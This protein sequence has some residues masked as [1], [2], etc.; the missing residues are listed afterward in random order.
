MGA[1]PLYLRPAQAAGRG[2]PGAEQGRRIFATASRLWHTN[3]KRFDL[4]ATRPWPGSRAVI[5]RPRDGVSR[6]LAGSRI[7]MAVNAVTAKIEMAK[8]AASQALRTN[9]ARGR[10]L[11]NAHSELLKVRAAGALHSE[12]D[13]A[14]SATNQ[15]EPRHLIAGNQASKKTLNKINGALKLRGRELCCA[16]ERRRRR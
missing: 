2:T 12:A 5:P 4:D 7:C 10:N 8:G 14:I 16:I 1:T 13:V 6:A 9:Q 3:A 11:R 15:G